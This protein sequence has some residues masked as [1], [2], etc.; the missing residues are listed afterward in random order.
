MNMFKAI[1]TARKAIVG[2]SAAVFFYELTKAYPGGFERMEFK[3]D[4]VLFYAVVAGIVFV[5]PNV[6]KK[7]QRRVDE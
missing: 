3:L 5:V 6:S 4:S 7:E 2:G 1:W